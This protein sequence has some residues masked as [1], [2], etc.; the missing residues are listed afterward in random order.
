MTV[1]LDET[2]RSAVSAALLAWL[3]PGAG[4]FYLRRPGTAMLFLGA[5][6]A[7]F[8]LGVAMDSRLTVNLGLDDLLAS[9]F[10]LAQMAIGV[11]YFA[12]RA[13]GFE[14]GQVTSVTHEYGN[15]FTAVGGLLNILVILDAYDT[16]VGRKP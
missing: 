3:L 6:G 7:L 4:H 14:A 11:P 12:A 1:P 8:V 2:R 13:M 10:S 15:T 16:A 5:I 9:L